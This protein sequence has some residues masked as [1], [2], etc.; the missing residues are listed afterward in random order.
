MSHEIDALFRELTEASGLPGFERE[1][2]DVIRKY[3]EQYGSIEYD[4]LGSIIC[5][6][7]GT[8]QSPRIMLAGHMD[9][10][11]F[12][13]A[14]IT[15][16]GFIKFQ[17]VGGWFD[18]VLL[19]QRVVV[20]TARGDV[21]GIIGAKAPH[22][23][24]EEDR[25][26]VVQMKDMFIDV[27]ASSREEAEGLGIRPG[28]PILP[29]SGFGV[30]GNGKV[31][32]AKAW[33]DRV[34]CALF[35][36][37]L[38]RLS[39]VNHPNTVYAVGTVQEEVGLRGATTASHIVNPDV[40]FA[41]EVDVS[42]GTPGLEEHEAPTRLGKGPALTVYDASMVPSAKLRDFVISVAKETGVP[43]QF[44][45]MARGGTDAG[46]MHIHGAG[47]PS[48]VIG[49]PSRYIHSHV[50]LIHRDDFESAAALM[51]SVIE[52]LDAATAAEFKR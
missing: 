5:K 51:T 11:G 25:K 45:Y 23:M 46:K 44:S 29:V 4:G 15:E 7:Q 47:V 34:G 28:D 33:D 27:G 31:L 6:K 42:G 14:Y 22:L 37:V 52:R 3:C 38:R 8:A 41:L 30:M 19:A 32:M 17:G 1:V 13:V 49:V 43:L 35:I 9:E 10:V 26:K 48:L 20:K 24:S 21:P 39:G 2:R 18:Q 36:E 40:G 50:G 12:I 16:K